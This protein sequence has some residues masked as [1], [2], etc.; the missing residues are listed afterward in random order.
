[1]KTIASRAKIL[2]ALIAL[3]MVGALLLSGAFV[4]HADEYAMNTRNKHI[5]QGNVLVSGGRVLDKNGAVLTEIR[6][7]A[8]VYNESAGIRRATLHVLGESG[9]I[10][11]GVLEKYSADLVGY[12]LAT[13]VFT[14]VEK[15]GNDVVLTLDAELC[16]AA[17]RAMDGRKGA[18]GVYNYKTGEIVCMI[19]KPV[20]D[21]EYKPDDIDDDADWDGVYLNKFLYGQY[22][23]GS[24]FKT[25]TA[26]CAAEHLPDA[27]TRTFYCDGEYHAADGTVICN[28]VHGAVTLEEAF[29]Y[30]CNS[31]FA[32]IAD[33]LG[34]ENMTATAKKLGVMTSYP[35]NRLNTAK[36]AFDASGASHAE[37]GWAGIGQYTDLVNP[38]NM[39]ILAGAI[40]NN[41]TAALPYYVD[42]V[43][44]AAG[45]TV[46]NEK[47]K[48]TVNLMNTATASV[49]KNFMRSTVTDYYGESYFPDMQMCAKTGTAEVGG[50]KQP[51]AWMIGFSQREDFPYAFSVIVENA[52][53][54][55]Y[56]AGAVAS[57]VMRYLMNSA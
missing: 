51:H 3:F 7:G 25:V 56:N 18:M 33:E 39:M 53:S 11:G 1:M 50:D 44:S 2:F 28:D 23:P 19:S 47:T 27:L 31:V 40:A 52:G 57:E 37:L 13:G 21:P 9:F 55:Y 20:Y 48:Q 22:V 34:A 38:C 5:Y 12:N 54:G 32:Q 16:A 41:G 46:K 42:G 36:G 15:G 14:A 43:Y 6:D 30:S 26:A 45:A 29:N 49:L 17:Y 4:R 35:V 8:R 10:A 24:T